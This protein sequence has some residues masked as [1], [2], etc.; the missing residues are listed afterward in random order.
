MLIRLTG[1]INYIYYSFH[2]VGGGVALHG[3]VTTCGK[4]Y[5]IWRKCGIY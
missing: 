5:F 3:D 4:L 1:L 2:V